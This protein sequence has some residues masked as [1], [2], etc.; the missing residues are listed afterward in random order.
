MLLISF[1]VLIIGS[2]FSRNK[3]ATIFEISFLGSWK[4]IA[5]SKLVAIAL[6]LLPFMIIE[7]VILLITKNV[8][9]VAPVVM[10]VLEYAYIS[11]LASLSGSQLPLL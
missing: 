3:L 1:V 11:I 2:H 6:G 4:R 10:S 5:I 8:S 9:F 7:A